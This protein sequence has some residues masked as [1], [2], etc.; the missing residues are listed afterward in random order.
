[1]KKGSIFTH[2]LKS[3]DPAVCGHFITIHLFVLGKFVN[4]RLSTRHNRYNY[5]CCYFNSRSDILS[6][7]QIRHE[8]KTQTRISS[9]V[10]GL[11]NMNTA[12]RVKHHAHNIPMYITLPT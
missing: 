11:K 7:G 1:M 4:R 2:A 6:T 9:T 12:E 8:Q 5:F 10:P 3:L